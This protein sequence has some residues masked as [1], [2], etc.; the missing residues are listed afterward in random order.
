MSGGWRR[1]SRWAAGMG[2][3]LG[4]ALA[5]RAVA[6]APAAKSVSVKWPGGTVTVEGRIGYKTQQGKV[7]LTFTKNVRAV[8][9]DPAQ[10]I[11]LL[12]ADRATAEVA[13]GWRFSTIKANGGVRLSVQRKSGTQTQTATARCNQ[14]TIH[15]PEGRKLTG[16]QRF[17]VADLVGEVLLTL[18]APGPAGANEEAAPPMTLEGEHAQIWL[19][20][21]GYEGSIS[22]AD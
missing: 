11:E 20:A 2:L 5:V 10:R 18:P 21:D 15:N 16:D 17:L 14:A 8:A 7:V 1:A 19:T 6:A 12:H 22:G 3:V 9:Q 4:M 13:S